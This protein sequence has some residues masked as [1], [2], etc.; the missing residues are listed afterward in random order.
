MR[1]DKPEQPV[2]IQQLVDP[3]QGGHYKPLPGDKFPKTYPVD[4]EDVESAAGLSYFYRKYY[5]TQRLFFSFA[6]KPMY[7]NY[8]LMVN[9]FNQKVID[10][11]KADIVLVKTSESSRDDFEK[12]VTKMDVN[13]QYQRDLLSDKLYS[14]QKLERELT[15]QKHQEKIDKLYLRGGAKSASWDIEPEFWQK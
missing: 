3:P 11:S 8:E 10:M 4:F 12:F 2:L 14:L 7:C 6:K 13:S 5:I 9:A 1:N 15:W